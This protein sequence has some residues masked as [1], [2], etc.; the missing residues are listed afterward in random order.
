M[1]EE[2][3]RQREETLLYMSRHVLI[4]PGFWRIS[5]YQ[6]RGMLLLFVSSM[7]YLLPLAIA[8]VSSFSLI[9]HQNSQS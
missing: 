9:H 4:V 1:Q 8:V 5:E 3:E 7:W 2:E 6:Q